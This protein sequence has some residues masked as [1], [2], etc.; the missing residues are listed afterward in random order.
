M[1]LSFFPMCLIVPVSSSTLYLHN[2]E[3]EILRY[4]GGDN[5][6]PYGDQSNLLHCK[7][8]ELHS[9]RAAKLAIIII[10]LQ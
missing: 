1:M 7:L 4:P 2:L 8:H 5:A 10:T 3:I 9:A 6:A